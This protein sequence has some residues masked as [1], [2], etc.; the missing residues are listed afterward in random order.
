[1]PVGGST[2]APKMGLSLIHSGDK[3]VQYEIEP[4]TSAIVDVK[5]V[6]S[7]AV[8]ASSQTV[9]NIQADSLLY[10]VAGEVRRLP[11]GANGIAPALRVKQTANINACKFVVDAND[12][13]NPDQS[14]FIVSTKGADVTCGT[15]DDG[16][17]TI[18][19]AAAGGIS[20][21]APLVKVLGALHDFSTLAP[22]GW[23]TGNGILWPRVYMV[24]RMTGD[25]PVTRVV[26]G[27]YQ[28]VVAE[29]NNQLTVWKVNG[30]NT[31]AETRLNAATTAGTAWQSIGYDASNFY[32]YQNSSNPLTACTAASNWKMLKISIA[33][34][35]ATQ[36]ATGSGC[37]ASASMGTGLLYASVLGATANAAVSVNK[38]TGTVQTVQSMAVTDLATV[39]TSASGTHQMLL[40]LNQSSTSYGIK[41]IDETG[42]VVRLLATS[43]PM[44][45]QDAATV[46][47]NN[48]ENRTRF[49]SANP[50]S[51]SV[52]YR[53]AAIE[54]Y[55][56]P[57]Q[58]LSTLGMVTGFAMSPVYAS[59]IGSSSDFIG[60]V[61]VPFSIG[62]GTLNESSAKV[63]SLDVA[64]ANS[65]TATTVKH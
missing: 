14:Q 2:S 1:M 17:M 46:N 44:G 32:V 38:N 58:T 9:S 11:L 25:L 61:A 50:Y 6:K 33:T 28:A 47:L 29:Y 31:A 41:M 39:L 10:I 23:V 21:N 13:A 22:T 64:T 60:G 56:A 8:N 37:I 49:F 4:T 36:L 53:D 35:V 48:S 65:L 59:V 27:N 7:G 30:V 63:F 3:S 57:T 52:G 18:A 34:P 62:T 16:Q 55:D 12:Y 5:V 45:L 20:S 19:L 24:M 40:M 43:F 51:S 42:T 15:A 26:I 54:L